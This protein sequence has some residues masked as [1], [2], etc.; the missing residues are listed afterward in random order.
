MLLK[1][2]EV[3]PRS[4]GALPRVFPRLG[5]LP[6]APGQPL[7]GGTL[8]YANFR[9]SYWQPAFAALGLP[10]VTP[11]SARHTFISTLQAQGVEIGLVAKLAGHAN[12][13]VT[14][15][16]YTQAV[17]GASPA[18]EALQRAYE[19]GF[20]EAGNASDSPAAASPAATAAPAQDGAERPET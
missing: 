15:N 11:H 10:Y 14:L 19:A 4:D 20:P 7:S 8:S 5:H 13:T 12:A 6:A 1:W 3:C 9:K 17:R 2:R 18:I 16:H